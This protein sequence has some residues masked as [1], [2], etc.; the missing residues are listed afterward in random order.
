MSEVYELKIARK[1]GSVWQFVRFMS[2]TT[3]NVGQDSSVGIV[4]SWWLDVTR[5]EPRW[6]TRFSAP[7]QTGPGTHPVSYTMDTWSFQEV[8]RPERGADH[9]PQSSAG[10]KGIVEL[11]FYFAFVTSEQVMGWNL[12]LNLLPQNI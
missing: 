9:P 12:P 8:E 7:I 11:Y 5:I 3:Q 4:T 10:V 2:L 6:E 1:T